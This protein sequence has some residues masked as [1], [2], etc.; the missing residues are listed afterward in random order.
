MVDA[1]EEAVAALWAG[2]CD[3]AAYAERLCDR[4]D[5]EDRQI[6]AFLSEPNRHERVTAAAAEVA[7]RHDGADKRPPLYGV[8]VGIKDIVHADGFETRAGSAFPPEVLAGPQ[9]SVVTALQEAGAVVLGK[10]VTTEFAGQAP[11]STRNP[12]NL[13][14]TPGG[15]S[16]GSAAAVAAGMTPLA[17]GTQTG[18]SVIRPAA[19][20]GIVGFKP[21]IDQIPTNGV[22]TRS[23]SLDTVGLFTRSVAGMKQASPAVCADWEPVKSADPPVLGVPKGAYLDQAEERALAA[24]EEQADA[25]AAAGYEVRRVEAFPDFETTATR[26]WDL[27]AA[28][29]TLAHA[30]WVDEYEPFYRTPTAERLERGQEVSTGELAAGREYQDRLRAGLHD[31]MNAAGVDVWV[32]P[33]APGPAPEGLTDTGDP[34]MNYPWTYAGLPAVTVPADEVDG[35]PVGLQCVGRFGAD[36]ELLAQVADVADALSA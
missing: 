3:P 9:A 26:Y 30:E 2:E 28:E 36:E 18:G 27:T 31:R 29:M 22:V 1:L 17:V 5:G 32:C 23:A 19:F 16:S 12:R 11:G 8:P 10:T 13:D 15:S 33:A 34:K 4:I 6:R 21:T 24:F 35:L 7:K 14:H 20:C 25:L